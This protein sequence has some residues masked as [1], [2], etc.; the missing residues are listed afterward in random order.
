MCPRCDLVDFFRER[1]IGP[2]DAVAY[3]LAFAVYVASQ[4]RLDENAIFAMMREGFDIHR[5]GGRVQ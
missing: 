5:V 4:R 2:D 3:A 1:D